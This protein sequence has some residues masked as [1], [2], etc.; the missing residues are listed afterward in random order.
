MEYFENLAVKE[1][2]AR[3]KLWRIEYEKTKFP[4]GFFDEIK[5][6]VEGY[7]SVAAVFNSVYSMYVPFGKIRVDKRFEI[8]R[9]VRIQHELPISPKRLGIVKAEAYVIA[10]ESHHRA[11]RYAN[12]EAVNSVYAHYI[13][14]SK[15]AEIEKWTEHLESSEHLD[16]KMYINIKANELEA[17][18]NFPFLEKSR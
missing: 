10:K 12:V 18:C 8:E 11:A 3:Y 14:E 13:G 2:S 7:Y 4:E 6:M 9:E 17:A 16:A 5:S 15:L 1:I